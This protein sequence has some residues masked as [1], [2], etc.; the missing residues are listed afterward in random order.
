MK[1]L[2]KETNLLRQKIDFVKNLQ[3]IFPEA[4]FIITGS[5]AMQIHSI[6]SVDSGDLDLVLLQPSLDVKNYFRNMEILSPAYPDTNK[7]TFRYTRNVFSGFW[8]RSFKVDVFVEDKIEENIYFTE[9]NGC[10]INPI[11][12]ILKE[13]RGLGRSKDY[14]HFLKL[15]FD[16]INIMK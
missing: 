2:R 13:K 7:D 1:L 10:L 8:F 14:Q 12:R 16:L 11:P 6:S 15:L 9:Y 5:T 3:T 4:I